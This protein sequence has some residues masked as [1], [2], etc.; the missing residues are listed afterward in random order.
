MIVDGH[1]HFWD[2]D[3]VAYPWL[4]PAYGPIHRSFH[5]AELEP[6]LRGAGVDRTVLVQ[7]ANSFE[8]TDAMLAQADAH[9]WIGAV[10]GWVPLEDPRAAAAALDDRYLG[11]TKYRGVRHLNHEEADPDWLVR[12]SVLE[13]I[14]ELESRG[15]V[16]EVVAVHPLHL[17]HVPTLATT[18]PDLRI[19]VDHLA[20]PPVGT[21][22][23]GGWE[24]DLRRAA[25][26]PNVSAKVSGLSTDGSWSQEDVTRVIGVALDAFGPA[27]L[28]FGSDWPVAI[29]GG[30]YASVWGHTTRALDSLGVAGADRD[31]ILGGT[32]AATYRIG[33]AA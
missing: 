13:G 9:D 24:R 12:P 8:D 17:G 23:L 31:A 16:Y 26:H 30:D 4:V 20:K 33:G 22:D 27:R 3:R 19:V 10:V 21:G 18:F 15:L 14:R 5:P 1:Q 25:A 2:L 7:S 32:A 28:M 6:Q 11:R 29:L